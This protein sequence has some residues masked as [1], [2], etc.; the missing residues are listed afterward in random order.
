[1]RFCV[2]CWRVDEYAGATARDDDVFE[3]LQRRR[4]ATRPD[5]I[6]LQRGRVKLTSFDA[7]GNESVPIQLAQCRVPGL[8]ISTAEI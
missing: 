2:Y 3:R 5:L 1:M 4:T 6:C 7:T 8:A